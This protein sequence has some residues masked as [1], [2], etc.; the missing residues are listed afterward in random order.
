M[1]IEYS[2]ECTKVENI[3]KI[4][5]TNDGPIY[6]C[7]LHFQDE[8]GHKLEKVENAVVVC[9]EIQQY[10]ENFLPEDCSEEDYEK[11]AKLCESYP[12]W[13]VYNPEWLSRQIESMV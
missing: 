2:Y 1:G 12:G 11:F 5:E 3:R 9:G 10:P 6:L 4:G 7:D 8:H 13:D